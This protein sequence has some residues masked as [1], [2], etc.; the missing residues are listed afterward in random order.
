MNLAPHLNTT[1]TKTDFFNSADTALSGDAFYALCR[2]VEALYR[3]DYLRFDYDF[4]E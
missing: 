1:R 3:D 4:L 2:K